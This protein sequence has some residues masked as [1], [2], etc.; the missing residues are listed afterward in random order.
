MKSLLLSALFFASTVFQAHAQAPLLTSVPNRTSISLDGVWRIIVDPYETGVGERYY[1]DRKPRDTTDLVQYD[2][3]ASETLN[4]PGDWNTQKEKL[5]WYEGPVWYRKLFTYTSKPDTRVFA[6]FGASNYRTRV[7]LNGEKLGEHEG[8]FTPFDFEITGK[9]RSGTNTLVLEVNNAR[10]V[11][12]VPALNTDWWNYGGLTRDVHLIEVPGIFIQDYVI[13]MAKGSQD[14]IAGWVQLN[15]ATRPQHVTVEIPEVGLKQTF[16]ANSS[17][18]AE[19][20]FPAKLQ[21][22]SPDSPKLYDVVITAGSDTVRDAI[23]FRTIETHGREILLNGKPIFLR[24]ISMHEEAPFRSGRAFSEEDAQTLF[25]W[26]RDLGCNFVRLAHYPHNENEIRLADRMGLLLWSEIPVYWDID[27]ENPETLANAKAQ[28]RDM[29]ARDH[30]RASVIFWSLSNETPIKPERLAFLKQLAEAARQQDSTRLITSAMNHVDRPG[31]ELHVLSDPLG[32]YL[33]VLGLNEYIGW[34]EGKIADADRMQWKIAYDKP[35]IVSEFGADALY[36]HHD[37]A[38]TRWTEEYQ[39]SLFE[40][41]IRMV[42]KIPGLVGLSPWLLMDFHT[43]RR[44]LPGIQD[45]FNRKGL[46]SNRGERKQAFFVLQKFYR[47]MAAVSAPN[48]S[49]APHTATGAIPSEGDRG[50]ARKRGL[51]D[52]GSSAGRK[53]PRLRPG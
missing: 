16:T 47:E 10:R 2:F 11:E 35:V 38:G 30:N 15:G 39:A 33:D 6:Y 37:D 17:G 48:P 53:V 44:P 28:L 8:G 18:L 45:Y 3:D 42:R 46:I 32:Q 43:P 24:G 27:W 9:L 51:R 26:A 25:G 1:E 40:H 49:A 19:F 34:Y 5:F 4:V 14:E 20:R 50:H 22:W 31:P 13:Q 41:Q 52:P 12:G 23:G 21:L 7:Y 36:G 29:I